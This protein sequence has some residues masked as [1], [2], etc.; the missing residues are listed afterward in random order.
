MVH[1]PNPEDL[2]AVVQAEEQRAHRGRLKIF[3]GY[4]AGVGKT[5]AMLEAARQKREEGVQVLVGWVDTHGRI[6]TQAMLEGLEVLPRRARS[7]RE[8]ELEE[9][10]LDQILELKPQLVLVDELAHTNVPGSRHRKRWQDVE[11]LLKAGIDVYTTLNIQHLES[12]NDVVAQ[13]TRVKVRE[14][15]PDRVLDEADEIKLID[16]PP[17]ELLQRLKEG[18]VYIPTQ[19]RYAAE[20]FFGPGKLAALRELVMRRAAER[21]DFQMRA[22]MQL[23][24]IAGPWPASERLLVCVGPSPFSERLIRAT[25]RL[26]T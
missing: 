20:N 15:L 5:Y 9:L 4:C 21:V 11:E 19:A 24:A 13:I 3:L 2:L 14:T 12:L 7:Y 8:V 17:E 1:R 23:M 26:A 25:R 16:L 6:E 10:D 18:K 22:H